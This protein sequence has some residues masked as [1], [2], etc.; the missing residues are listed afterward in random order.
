MLAACPGEAQA[1]SA[2]AA[3][4]ACAVDPLTFIGRM[5]LAGAGDLE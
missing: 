1:G 5:L 2:R 4:P 3:H